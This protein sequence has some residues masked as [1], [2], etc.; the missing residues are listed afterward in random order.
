MPH[1]LKTAWLSVYGTL[2][3]YWAVYGGLERVILSP[4]CWL[5]LIL[6]L[7][8]YPF[9]LSDS[10]KDDWAQ[11]AIDIVP[12]LLGF[13]IGAFAVLL[14]FTNPRFM[15]FMSEEGSEVSAYM[16][17]CA[18]FVHFIV[19]QSVALLF[20]IFGKFVSHG[21]LAGVGFFSFMYAIT[22]A[23]ATCFA[24]FNLAQVYNKW[25]GMQPSDSAD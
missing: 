25:S 13:S 14:A 18:M 2:R 7:L 17:A 8:S 1:S 12:S 11:V 15:T 5:A 22:T 4:Y 6:T 3:D 23:V 24:L 19:V 21:M 20:A 10:P 9:W 16:T